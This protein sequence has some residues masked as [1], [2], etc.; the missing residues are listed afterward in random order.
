MSIVQEIR[1]NKDED[2]PMNPNQSLEIIFMILERILDY[3]SNL[4]ERTPSIFDHYNHDQDSDTSLLS[5]STTYSHSSSS[6]SNTSSILDKL[7]YEDFIVYAYKK[8][9][10]SSHLLIL[11]MMNLDKLLT[12]KFI[13]TSENIHKAFFICMMETQKYYEDENF[14]NKDYAK[15]CGITTDELLELELEFMNYMDFN[16]NIKDEEYIN[17]KNKLQNLYKKNIIISNEYVQIDDEET[18]DTSF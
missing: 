16:I 7:D 15:V 9:G 6:D 14:K 10:F 12:K 2:K 11:S 4:E 18:E 17:Y 3:T 5:V 13:L 8:L 1:Y